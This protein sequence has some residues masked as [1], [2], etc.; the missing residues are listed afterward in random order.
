[1]SIEIG[2]G[3]LKIG[4]GGGSSSTPVIPALVSAE[5]NPETGDTDIIITLDQEMDETSIPDLSCFVVM[6]NGDANDISDIV[7]Y[8]HKLD[9]YSDVAFLYGDTITVSYT[10]PLE[11]PLQG[12]DGGKVA[13]FTDYPVVNNVAFTPQYL[14]DKLLFWG[15][16]ADIA[17]G[18]M[19]NKITGA[20][21]ALT[22][23]GS[24]G[25]FTFQCPDTAPYIAA[26]TDYI[27][28]K[29]D[30]T[31]RTTTEAELVGYDFPRTLVKY[32][33]TT[34]YAIRE[35]IVLL[36]GETL[37][38]AEENLLRDYMEL[39]IW[40]SDVS[41]DH[42]VT[43][44]NRSA[45]QSVWTVEIPLTIIGDG[46]TVAWYL[47]QDTTTITKGAGNLVSRWNDKLG[48][49]HDLIQATESD[50]PLWS[51]EGITFDG[52]D[53]YLQTVNFTFNMPVFIYA[54]IKQISYT[55]GRCMIDGK[56][57]NYGAVYQDGTTPNIILYA[58]GVVG[59]SMDLVIGE[60][61]IL[62]ALFNGVSS[63]LIVDNHTPVTGDSG[64][65][66]PGGI[67]LGANGNIDTNPVSGFSNIAFKELVF[68]DVSD[69]APDE[70][71]IYS[72]LKH[73]YNL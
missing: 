36:A 57:A 13:S 69:S 16:V 68:R 64:S 10:A 1:M 48:S 33:N 61:G 52:I 49:G 41:S 17:A 46:H 24:A 44:G 7:Y 9:L 21:D 40:W 23:G 38:T 54:V 34:P 2:I 11:N 32:D 70:L 53:N 71:S 72:Y 35:I 63:K 19:A 59:G 27:W 37:T 58:G 43:K 42:G 62:R 18:E 73:K 28:F 31:L 65:Q 51:S 50:K 56:K 29:T 4:S 12:L 55:S 20:T 22:V 5:I 8:N 60:W 6:R 47:S 66:N 15:T 67:T 39:S 26:D 25:T 45:E 30:E 14:A 3:R